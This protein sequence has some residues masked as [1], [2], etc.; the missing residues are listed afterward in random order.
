M[1]MVRP[2]ADRVEL[3]KAVSVP[4]PPDLA[5]DNAEMVG[6]FIREA[7]RQSG[8]GAKHAVMAV[9]RDQVF[10]NTLTLPPTPADDL[11][12]LIQFQVVKELPFSAEQATID[13]A[14]AA[15]HDPKSP[16]VALVAA[17]RDDVVAF[18]KQVAQEAGL[19][20]ERIGLRPYAN[21]RA[22]LASM[23]EL[24]ARTV[25]MVE[26]GPVHT[27]ISV[28]Q[29]GSLV[30]SRA[31]LLP[32][33]GLDR[34]EGESVLDSRIASMPVIDAEQD[35]ISR[36]AVGKLM[37]EI[38]RT[39][40]GYRATSSHTNIDQIMVCGS[41]GLEPELSQSLA[42]RFAARAQLFMPDRPLDLSQQRA[43]ELRG[44]SAALGLAIGHGG[45][46]LESFN[47]LAP[48]KP[49]SKRTRQ[50]RKAPAAVMAAVLLIGAGVVFYQQ[51]V[52]PE[53]AKT[54]EVRKLLENKQKIDK[55]YK[56]FIA[57]AEMLESWKKSEQR[58][59]ELLVALTEVFPPEEKACVDRI[60][61]TMRGGGRSAARTS[62]LSMKLRVAESG[63]INR[64]S[65]LLR[66][67]GFVDTSPESEAPRTQ[68]TDS[69][70]RF[71]TGLKAEI[72]SRPERLWE[73][74][75]PEADPDAEPATGAPEPAAVSAASKAS[76]EREGAES[77]SKGGA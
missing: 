31:A 44:F 21:F 26:A 58:W 9:P 35:E 61:L 56:E 51:K 27:E 19:T 29:G 20:L 46:P 36:E 47:F 75:A 1:A 63:E 33:P 45:P 30:F 16:S 14:I 69:I 77:S 13:F 37:V 15:G 53:L 3:L 72:P 65:E 57:E 68:R 48:K 62:W 32:L 6:A 38:I 28:I 22:V 17:A 42:A 34:P 64:L 71:D 24:S 7:M 60:D 59:P 4:F 8:L 55:P 76:P 67:L 43:K 41:T 39:F 18:Y 74:E 12:A 23:P 70:Y 66:Q 52:T 73:V 49:I 2:R 25:L 10:V 5:M 50:L 11:P 54:E 40:E